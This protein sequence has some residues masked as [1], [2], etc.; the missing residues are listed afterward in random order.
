MSSKKSLWFL[1]SLLNKSVVTACL[2]ILAV[3]LAQV[4]SSQAP[5]VQAQS[6]NTTTQKQQ[7]RELAAVRLAHMLPGVP[8]VDL[9][10]DGRLRLQDVV[11]GDVSGYLLIPIDR[12][13]LGL[14]PQVA[15][16]NRGEVLSGNQ[17]PELIPITTTLEPD[18]YYTIVFSYT[19]SPDR[20]ERVFSTTLVSIFEDSFDIPLPGQARV[21]FNSTSSSAIELSIQQLQDPQE[22]VDW[23]T[24][25]LLP[26]STVALNIPLGSYVFSFTEDEANLQVIVHAGTYYTFYIFRDGE[27]L[28]INPDVDGVLGTLSPRESQ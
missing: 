4:A 28:V 17:P 2:L 5:E 22:P 11:Y 15:I 24:L 12:L 7:S 25:E 8:R 26:L 23:Q 18:K 21:R 19:D 9:T 1:Q 3:A 14:M 13:R 27:D 16:N 20:G 10:V 6:A